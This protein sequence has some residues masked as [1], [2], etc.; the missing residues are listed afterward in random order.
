MIKEI[1]RLENEN[2]TLK[3]LM[4]EKDLKIKLQQEFIKKTFRCGRKKTNRERIC[5]SRFG[6]KGGVG[7]SRA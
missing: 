4:V 6:F 5:G 7:S 3:E 1:K 2:T